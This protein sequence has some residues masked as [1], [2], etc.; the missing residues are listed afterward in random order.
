MYLLRVIPATKIPLLAPQI[1]T[2]F[3]A[4]ALSAGSLVSIPIHKRKS[5]G[6]V[7]DIEKIDGQKMALRKAEFELR[8]IAKVI[9]LEKIISENQLSLAKWMSEYY[10]CPVGAI[11]KLMIPTSLSSLRGGSGRR[12][13]L[14]ESQNNF[15]KP[16]DQ[17]IQKLILVPEI[18]LIEKIAKKNK[19]MDYAV[20]HSDLTD[21]QYYENWLRIKSNNTQYVI[22]T[23]M[24]LF[25][26]FKN[27]K[28]IIIENEHSDL[29]KSRQTPRYHAREVA[30]KLAETWNAKIIFKS[31]T[32]SIETLWFAEKNK[33]NKNWKLII[34][35]FKNENANS[36]SPITNLVDLREELKAGNFSIFS[37]LLLEKIK[38]ALAKNQ[39]IILFIN[40]RGASTVLMCRDCG[41]TPKCPNCDVPLV[42]HL[43]PVQFL[44]HH[45]GHQE[46]PPVVCPNCLGTRIKFFGIGSQKVEIEFKKLFSE[47][48]VTRLDSD[49]AKKVESVEN[50]LSCQ[51]QSEHQIIDDFNSK[52]TQVLIGTSILFNKELPRVPLA[53][54]MIADTML[55]LPDFHSNERTFQIISQLKT[56]SKK[57]FILQ[58]YSPENLAIRFAAENNLQSFYAEEIAVRK[59]FSYPPFSQLIKLIYQNKNADKAKEE[60]KILAEKL[61]RQISAIEQ[62]SKLKTYK[63]TTILG[64][65][66]AF[67]PK[68][69]GQYIWQIILKTKLTDLKLRNK[70]LQIVPPDWTVNVNPL[71]II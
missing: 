44:C 46:F 71:Q 15:T 53:A 14:T 30:A 60:A 21:K 7:I 32:P 59:E 22:A 47:A 24:G 12:S 38:I 66:P 62:S 54:M 9:S 68:I 18:S 52:K 28:E 11:I 34:N 3:S 17:A 70:I 63:L 1:L 2:Y 55:H 23:R 51:R 35:N 69:N 8:G 65:S 39:Q 36:Q 50:P 40:R 19:I 42:Y 37:R 25:A 67:I 27:L 13:N 43:S 64:P 6:V 10:W 20:L 16:Q 49:I 33:N 56:L 48:K 61:K 4:Q 58:T 31:P 41:Y 29:Y 5:I 26:P 57:E 45:C